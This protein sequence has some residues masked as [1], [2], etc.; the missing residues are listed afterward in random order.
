MLYEM[1][2]GR[3]PFAGATGAEVAASILKEDPPA[4]EGFRT[5]LP[6]AFVRIVRRC[7]EKDPCQ[8]QHSAAD[9]RADLAGVEEE[10]ASRPVGPSA[11]APAA[12]PPGVR[13]PGLRLAA[14][15]GAAA[16]LVVLAAFLIPRLRARAP[17]GALP[18]RSIAV[19]PF[20]N[21]AKEP[22]QDYFVDGMHDALITDLAKLGVLKVTSRT[23]VMRYRGQAK[24]LKEVAEELGVDALIEGSVLR[25]GNRVRITAQLIRGSTDEHIWAESYDRNLEDVLQLL[26]DVSRSI[27]G[28]VRLK[29]AG[30]SG[31][32]LPPEP[33]AAP[34]VRPEAWEAY[35]KGRQV[36]IQGLLSP[37]DFRKALGPFQQAVDLDPGFAQGWSGLAMVNMAL[38][39]FRQAPVA[40]VLPKAREAALKAIALDDR[41]GEA[42]GVLGT[43]ELY[44][45]WN[46]DS[47]KLHLERAVALTPHDLFIRHAWADYLMVTGRFEES[48]EQVKIGRSFEPTSPVA[49]FVVLFHTRA[50]RRFDE[51]IA[52]ARRVTAAFPKFGMAH[53]LLGDALWYKEKYDEA[54]AEYKLQLGADSEGVRLLETELR[55]AGPRAALKAYADYVAAQMQAGRGSA[56]GVASAFAE[57]GE[58]DLAFQ[59][60]EKAY[61]ERAPQLLH[62]VAEPSFDGIRKDPRYKALIHRIGVPMAN[63]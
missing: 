11:A 18:I 55:R 16:L 6:A 17:S 53:G 32:A 47:A 42:Y 41:S 61:A 23:T 45:D 35:L 37:A 12:A 52:E 19:L 21:L 2:S 3:R 58:G 31:P 57:A 15:A 13:R 1:A 5:D 56:L 39:F 44:F 40:E 51:V 50:T 14:A 25:S 24:S 30:G 49:E 26:R 20:E 38:G 22:A 60:L 46:F 28:E 33:A 10:L 59:W 7:L 54:I 4:L 27:A 8:R 34:K 63:Q 43:I 48:L 62:M 29:L 9:L 36:M